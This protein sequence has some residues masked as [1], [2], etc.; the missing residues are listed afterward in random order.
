MKVFTTEDLKLLRQI[1]YGFKRGNALR[2]EALLSKADSMSLN[3]C[4][5]DDGF[6]ATTRDRLI[7]AFHVGEMRFSLFDPNA[8]AG[9]IWLPIAAMP[10]DN[11]ER[12]L[13]Y[14]LRPDRLQEALGDFDEGFALMLDRHGVGYARR[15]YW[16]Q[17]T[18]L[19]ARG[20]FDAACKAAKIWGG[21]GPD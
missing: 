20:L 18:K 4:L 3:V 17:V 8:E 9:P 7:V 10:P 16:V 13:S 5:T 21:F 11:A 15:W 14:L 19:A 2:T 6:M 12:V 1:A